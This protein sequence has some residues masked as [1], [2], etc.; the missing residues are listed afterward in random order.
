MVFMQSE[1]TL[2]ISFPTTTAELKRDGI[3]KPVYNLSLFRL[4]ACIKKITTKL[5]IK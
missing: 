1:K 5:M 4:R 2:T 3:E